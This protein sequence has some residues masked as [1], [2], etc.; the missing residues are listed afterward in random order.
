MNFYVDS[1]CIV[2]LFT[3][4]GPPIPYRDDWSEAYASVLVRVEVRRALHRI[5]IDGSLDTRD[6]ERAWIDLARVEAGVQWLPLGDDILTLA[7]EPHTAPLKTLDALHLATAQRVRE[8]LAPDLFF[9]TH[10]RQLASAAIA[11][12]FE[13]VGL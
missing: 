12:G 5:T 2:R 8:T 1:S 9:A 6:I 3:G 7:S 11:M 13:V 4:D 10:D